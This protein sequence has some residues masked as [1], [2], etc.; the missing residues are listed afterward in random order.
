MKILSEEQA[1]A[2]EE[3]SDAF[4]YDGAVYGRFG[5]D[6]IRLVDSREVNP[7]FNRIFENT[8]NMVG[9]TLDA[10]ENGG[11]L[12]L[13]WRGEDQ[14]MRTKCFGH[15]CFGEYILDVEETS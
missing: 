2:L 14:T 15:N 9:W 6:N 1:L 3:F 8:P 10:L 11:E 5:L 4:V 7:S 13:Q 12:V